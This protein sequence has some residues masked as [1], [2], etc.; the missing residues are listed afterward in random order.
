MWCVL[1]LIHILA[2]LFELLRAQRQFLRRHVRAIS[3]AGLLQDVGRHL[4]VLHGVLHLQFGLL[5][6][7]LD[8]PLEL[9]YLPALSELTVVIVL[10]PH[11]VSVVLYHLSFLLLVV[12]DEQ[13]G[14]AVHLLVVFHVL[15]EH[16]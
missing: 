10:G 6:L 4:A 12:R 15:V 13:L 11:Q 9:S 8:G 2:A 5:E 16:R 3:I 7:L 1:I 14:K